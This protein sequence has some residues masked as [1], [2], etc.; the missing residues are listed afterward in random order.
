MLQLKSNRFKLKIQI[1][2]ILTLGL[3][4]LYGV[5]LVLELLVWTVGKNS[6]LLLTDTSMICEEMP[7]GSTVILLSPDT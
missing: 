4:I 3:L 7:K 2:L 1:R 5:V 6:T